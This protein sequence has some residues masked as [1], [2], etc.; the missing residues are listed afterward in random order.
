VTARTP[1]FRELVSQWLISHYVFGAVLLLGLLLVLRQSAA[2]E[3]VP[4]VA[5]RS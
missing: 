3:S 1:W 4:S 2:R 5:R